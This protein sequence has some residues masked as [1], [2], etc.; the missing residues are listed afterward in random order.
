MATYPN[1]LQYK[2][3]P[4]DAYKEFL[5]E[6][7]AIKIAK[8]SLIEKWDKKFGLVK[9]F[10]EKHNRLPYWWY[11][12]LGCTVNGEISVKSESL[13]KARLLCLA[14]ILECNFKKQDGM[15]CKKRTLAKNDY[16]KDPFKCYSHQMRCPNCTDWID[17]H[18][19]NKKY[20]NY[21]ARCF[22]RLFPDDPRSLV[23]Y[24]HSKEILVRNALVKK[25]TENALFKDFIHD[26]PLY[27]GDC[28]CMHRRRIDHRKLFGNT[29]LA[30]ETDEFG[31]RGYDTKDELIRY[32]DV[33]M[34]HSGKWVFIRFNPDNTKQVKV[35][36]K[37]RIDTL[38]MEIEKQIRRIENE[39][40]TEL[41]EIIRLFY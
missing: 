24:E 12:I 23:I 17:S 15:L 30:I 21:C 37:T 10:L 41:V 20:D 11:V 34:I 9:G 19:P 1:S 28:K 33:Y 16:S 35:D 32:D 39:M 25:A 29:I 5:L 8:G 31:H 13:K 4:E 18:G 7:E 14:Q 40:N 3:Y 27:T 36:I 38:L 2:M 22:K 6:L 26:T